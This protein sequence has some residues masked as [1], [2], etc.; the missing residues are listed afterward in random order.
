MEVGILNGEKEEKSEDDIKK[1]FVDAVIDKSIKTK[2]FITRLN[3]IKDIYFDGLS[4][5]EGIDDLPS[6]YK[7]VIVEVP[8]NILP[9]QTNK[10]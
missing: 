10:M 3:L 8:G 1:A 9:T 2:L 7:R 6:Q 4:K 5:Y